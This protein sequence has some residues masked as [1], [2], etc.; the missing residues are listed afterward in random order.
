MKKPRGVQRRFFYLATLIIISILSVFYFSQTY[1]Y[2]IPLSFNDHHYPLLTAEI[3]G[4]GYQFVFG[5]SSKIDCFLNKDILATLHNK[6]PCGMRKWRDTTGAFFDAPSYIIPEMK[7]GAIVLND[8]VVTEDLRPGSS[9]NSIGLFF[10]RKFNVLLNFPESVIIVSN[11]MNKLDNLGFRLDKMVKIALET[12]QG[13]VITA[14]TD[15]GLQKF[16]VA[17]SAN[18]NVLRDTILPA[19]ACHDVEPRFTSSHLIIAGQDFGRTDFYPLALS[20]ALECDGCLGMD[21]LYKHPVY[22][23]Y[24]QKTIYITP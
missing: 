3:E 11:D 23:A 15:L 21:F 10:I 8:V 9:E 17:T 14:Q 13:L 12:K 16:S 4:K 5:T 2:V 1:F 19:C 7:I 24:G 22:I 6:K 20:S 18:M